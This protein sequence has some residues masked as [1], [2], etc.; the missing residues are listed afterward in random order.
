MAYPFKSLPKD[1]DMPQVLDAILRFFIFVSLWLV[2]SFVIYFFLYGIPILYY[3]YRRKRA[4]R[5]RRHNRQHASKFPYRLVAYLSLAITPLAYLFWGPF[6]LMTLALSIAAFRAYILQKMPAAGAALQSDPRPPVLYLRSFDQEDLK[7]VHVEGREKTAYNDLLNYAADVRLPRLERLLYR[8]MTMFATAAENRALGVLR[9]PE[10]DVTFEKYFR[11]EVLRRIGPFVA[12]GNPVD[13]LPAEGAYRE[14]QTDERWKDVFH[15]RV[16]QCACVVMQWGTTNNLQFE[17]TS[18]LARG[19]CHKLFIL[20]PPRADVLDKYEWVRT[21]LL[22]EKPA[23][24]ET[25]SGILRSN[26]YRLPEE[27]PG[28][29]SVLTFETDGRPVVLV[30]R[31]VTPGEYIYP[32]HS[33]LAARESTPAVARMQSAA[34]G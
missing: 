13:D 12:L 10:A 28:I 16:A 4:R 22:K 34:L 7:F 20:T 33:R 29:G 3:M 24:W 25:F 31:A 14:Y 9:V 17:L 6:G 27:P 2:L 21:S 8:F 30:Q 32:I 18:I 23:N 26:G 19:M 5:K 15:E 11:R 1:G